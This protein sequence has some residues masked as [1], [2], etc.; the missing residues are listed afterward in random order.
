MHPS[1]GELLGRYRLGPRLGAGGMGEVFRARDE[2]LERDVAIKM[3]PPGSFDDPDAQPSRP[4]AR[5]AET[6][7][8]RIGGS[9]PAGIR[10]ASGVARTAD[11]RH[12]IPTGAPGARPSAR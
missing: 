12:I 4:P 8:V 6:R 11:G 7:Q 1:E 9:K 10:R 2:Q 5:P 3:L